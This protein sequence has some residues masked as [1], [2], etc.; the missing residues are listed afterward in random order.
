MGNSTSAQMYTGQSL[1]KNAYSHSRQAMFA[2]NV[3]ALKMC[4]TFL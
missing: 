2:T 1:F 3:S 4:V